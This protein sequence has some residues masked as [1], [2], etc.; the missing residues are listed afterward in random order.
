[1]QGLA[2]E[3]ESIEVKE[4]PSSLKKA[5]PVYLICGIYMN[6]QWFFD[7]KNELMRSKTQFSIWHSPSFFD[8]T[9]A[10]RGGWWNGKHSFPRFSCDKQPMA[11]F[12]IR[13]RD[14]Q[15]LQQDKQAG[16][17]CGKQFR[18]QKKKCQK[19]FS[20]PWLP[21]GVHG[22]HDVHGVHCPQPC[23]QSS[24]LRRQPSPGSRV[25][26]REV[27]TQRHSAESAHAWKLMRT[28][29]LRDLCSQK[30]ANLR[31]L[32]FDENH[33]SILNPIIQ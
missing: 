5:T 11:N 7:F 13:C 15:N 17:N 18:V 9:K 1:M 31:G 27:R 6:L 8:S 33:K 2:Q 24:V 3:Q 32:L 28:E 23:Q 25:P 16:C 22:V 30:N 19:R 20:L 26:H 4:A 12:P 10:P 29:N 21:L 14:L